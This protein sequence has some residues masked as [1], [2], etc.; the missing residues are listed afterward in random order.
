MRVLVTGSHGYIGCVL[1][2]EIAQAGHDVVGLD[3]CFYEG[4]DFADDLAAIATSRR[5]VRDVTSAD[6]KGFDAIVHLAALSK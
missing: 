5:D 3:T 6:F 1:A 2:P 4:C